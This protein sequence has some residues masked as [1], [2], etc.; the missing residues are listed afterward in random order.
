ME[1]MVFGELTTTLPIIAGYV[2]HKGTW[3][4]RKPRAFSKIFEKPMALKAEGYTEPAETVS[5]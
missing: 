2:Y 5:R 4:N 1:Q 3:K